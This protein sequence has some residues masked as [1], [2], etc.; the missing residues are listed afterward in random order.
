MARSTCPQRSVA[1]DSFC[2]P[3]KRQLLGA[4]ILA[5]CMHGKRKSIMHAYNQHH[6]ISYY[7]LAA[8]SEAVKQVFTH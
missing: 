2:P 4:V 1:L 6:N 8:F 3:G 5:I 7:C